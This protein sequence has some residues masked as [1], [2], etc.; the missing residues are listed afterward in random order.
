[1]I[2]HTGKQRTTKYDKSSKHNAF[3]IQKWLCSKGYCVKEGYK[4]VVDNVEYWKLLKEFYKSL[5]GN[6]KYQ[7]D[8]VPE[9]FVQDNFKKFCVFCVN[10]YKKKS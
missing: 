7:K 4:Y 1:M 9:R 6:D 2:Y 8:V 5:T 3:G 10:K